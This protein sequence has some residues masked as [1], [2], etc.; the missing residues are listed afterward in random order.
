MR[1][2]LLLLFT[3][4]TL[5]SIAQESKLSTIEFVQILNNNKEEA[6][7]YFENNWA[8]LRD[9]AIENGYISSYQL[10][11][12]PTSVDQPFQIMLVTTYSNEQQYRDR[13]KHFEQLINTS[14]GLK[15]LNDKQP[16]DFRKSL[17]SKQRVQHLR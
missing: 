12:T 8:A 2:A 9:R 7:F 6:V 5:S 15:L 17:F 16:G 11:E 4:M 13:E 3:A 1:T 14:G 10:L